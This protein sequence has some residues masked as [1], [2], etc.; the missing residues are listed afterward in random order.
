[1]LAMS[2]SHRQAVNFFKMCIHFGAVKVVHSKSNDKHESSL[3]LRV[4]LNKS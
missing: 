2:L 4:A 3:S 1:M